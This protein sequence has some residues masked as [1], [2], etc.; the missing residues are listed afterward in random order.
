[1]SNTPAPVMGSQDTGAPAIVSAESLDKELGEVIER[2]RISKAW[3]RENFWDE[4]T[5]AW[6]QTNARAPQIID[7]KTGKED[8]SR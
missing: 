7:E 2:K 6:R 8:R 3:L 1:M 5:E 4:W